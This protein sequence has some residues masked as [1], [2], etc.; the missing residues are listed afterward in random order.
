MLLD[1][2][3]D[4][5]RIVEGSMCDALERTLT[6]K[7]IDHFEPTC[8]PEI[9]FRLGRAFIEVTEWTTHYFKDEVPGYSILEAKA[10]F[11][12]PQ[13]LVDTLIPKTAAIETA[14][15]DGITGKAW[16]SRCHGRVHRSSRYC[17]HCGAWFAE[18]ASSSSGGEQ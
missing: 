4:I 18:M 6:D 3:A 10:Y 2:D 5:P 15:K 9:V 11:K 17:Q 1:G 7:Q 8:G 14:T 12:D 13:E 16:C